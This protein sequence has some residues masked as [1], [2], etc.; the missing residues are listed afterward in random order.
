VRDINELRAF[1]QQRGDA[2]YVV[3]GPGLLTSLINAGL[4]DELRL[5]VHPVAVGGGTAVLGGV[6]QRQAFELLRTD[7]G[8]AGRVNLTYR[9][10]TL[11]AAAAA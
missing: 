2:V 8:A 5:I 11:A 3:G 9:L 4:L 1:K 7:P 6:A 10:K